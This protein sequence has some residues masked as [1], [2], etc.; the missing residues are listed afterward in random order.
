MAVKCLLIDDEAPAI[1]LLQKHISAFSDLEVVGTCH[2][3]IQGAELL[4]KNQVDLIFLDIQMPVLTGLDF[5]KTSTKLPKVILTTAHRNYALESYDYNVVDY[6]LKPISFD[7]FFKAIEKYY[8]QTPSLQNNIPENTSSHNA[9]LHVN[10]NKK[11]HKISLEDI[12]YIQSLKDYIRIHTSKKRFVVKG[13]IGAIETQLPKT[14]FIRVHRS[15]IV[16][17]N[18]I[19]A[20]T[21][22]DIE[23]DTIEIPIGQTYREKV[24]KLYT[25]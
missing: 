8:Q 24:K 9:F 7:R 1:D 17:I 18:K 11:M 12:L 16:A 20:Y 2:S 5:L 6:L 13:N 23:I 10:I 15:Y 22:M 21:T 4:K 25:T 14:L 19:T 3:A